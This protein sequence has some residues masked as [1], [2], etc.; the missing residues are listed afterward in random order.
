L[1]IFDCELAEKSMRVLAPVAFTAVA[2]VG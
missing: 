2:R 1:E